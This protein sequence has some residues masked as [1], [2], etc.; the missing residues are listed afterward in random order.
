[1]TEK[2]NNEPLQSYILV[3]IEDLIVEEQPFEEVDEWLYR[4]IKESIIRHGIL[5][6]I[7]VAKTPKGLVVQE[8]RTRYQIAKELG[9]KTIPCLITDKQDPETIYA[10]IYDTEVL[11]RSH[12]KEEVEKYLNEKEEKISKVTEII[13]QRKV[14]EFLRMLKTEDLK[15]ILVEAPEDIK[16]NLFRLVEEKNIKTEKELS[17]TINEEVT[18]IQQKLSDMKSELE[19][20]NR[21]LEEKENKIKELEEL[22]NKTREELAI[23]NKALD[24]VKERFEEEKKRIAEELKSKYEE[25]ISSAMI[26]SSYDSDNFD[27]DKEDSLQVLKEKER[28]EELE[29]KIEEK[30]R[31]IIKEKE[32]ELEEAKNKW[33]HISR[34]LKQLAEEKNQKHEEN[35]SLSSKIRLLEEQVKSYENYNKK[36]MERLNRVSGTETLIKRLQNIIEEFNSIHEILIARTRED[37]SEEE[38]KKFTEILDKIQIEVNRIQDFFTL[39]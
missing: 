18:K 26:G 11:R 35:R 7:L 33:I 2:N 13:N 30:Y 27:S 29:K 32:K 22:L 6:P 5:T 19:N 12:T 16:D 4:K 1:M 34:Q 25:E 28:L 8:G 14:S 9:L 21:E 23:R 20:K 37:F 38:V 31:A 39:E 36:L 10:R 3:P 15:R 24:K 17:N